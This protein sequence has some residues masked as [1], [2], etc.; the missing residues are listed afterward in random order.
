MGFS[1]FSLL[2]CSFRRLATILAVPLY[3]S[4]CDV[5]WPVLIGPFSLDL[6][7]CY[8]GLSCPI[9]LLV[10]SFVPCPPPWASFAHLL[11]LVIFGSFSN[12]IFPWVF[13]DSLGLSGPNYH[14]LHFWGSCIFHQ[15]LTF[16]LHYFGPAVAHSHFSTSHNAHGFTIYFFGLL[17]G[18]FASLKAHLLILW[19]YNPLFL[20]FGFNSSSNHPLILLCPYCLASFCYW[21]SEWASTSPYQEYGLILIFD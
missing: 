21:A 20:P 3:H 4:Y 13:T 5:I 1:S 10:G 6:Y 18:P 17:L 12:F 19:A 15:P 14:I 8:F 16:S 9:T 7:S 11:S 2:F